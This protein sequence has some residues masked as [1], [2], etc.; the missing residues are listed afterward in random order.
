MVVSRLQGRQ[1]PPLPAPLWLLC[2]SWPV[3][4]F[5]PRSALLCFKQGS[6]TGGVTSGEGP[7][8]GTT[9]TADTAEGGGGDVRGRC[10]S[11]EDLLSTR[12]FVHGLATQVHGTEEA[13]LD[14]LLALCTH[15]L[16]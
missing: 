13:L 15:T 7:E 9:T 1:D 6:N 16:T 14:T 12:D 2:Q 3:Q 5:T 8:G 4:T 11:P 10:L